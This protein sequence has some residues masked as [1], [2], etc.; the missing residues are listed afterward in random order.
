[1]VTK[2]L[3]SGVD[4][5]LRNILLIRRHPKISDLSKY[6]VLHAF[7]RRNSGDGLLV[8]L[9]LEALADAG[10]SS[11][12]VEI[13]AL[14]PDS[15]DNFPPVHRAPGEPFARFTPRLAGAVGELL[16]NQVASGEVNRLVSRAKGL[17]AVGGGYLVA[18]SLVRQA[19]VLLNHL[20]QLRSA[21][22]APIPSIYLPQSVGPLHGP[23]G[24]AV[25][26]NLNNVSLFCA[27]DDL[28]MTEI[29]GSNILR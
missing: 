11:E 26:K 13:L 21:A 2:I 28:T 15:F 12:Q 27:R 22:R 18:D 16:A 9:T 4:G 5:S 10:I 25:K 7:S 17:V 6:L 3:P 8:D 20:V 19:G 24:R 29:G 14:D 23:I 1:M